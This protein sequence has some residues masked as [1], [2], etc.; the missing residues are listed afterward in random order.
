MKFATRC[1]MTINVFACAM[2]TFGAQA[3]MNTVQEKLA[4][5]SNSSRV[6]LGISAVN[7]GN[8]QRIQYGENEH[9][10]MAS[11]FKVMAVSAILKQSMTDNTL[12]Q[13]HRT[14]TPDD[15]DSNWAP[16]TEK[17]PEG[18]TIE[19]LAQ[20][21]ISYSDS[22]AINVLVRELGG[23]KMVNN[24]ARSIGDHEY[25][26]QQ[27][28]STTTPLAMEKSFRK[29]VLG[30]DLAP[31]QQKLL[32]TW[33]VNNT[34]GNLRIRAGVPKN[35]VVGDKTGTGDYGLVNDVAVLWPPKCNPIVIAIYSNQQKKDAVR[36]VA[37]LAEATRM[38]LSDF[39]KKDPCVKKALKES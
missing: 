2:I 30:H 21:A 3:T 14:Y 4:A 22:T 9:F 19:G 39:S 26:L 20:A 23:N 27:T 12:L 13:Q 36:K 32:Q 25:Q 33:L 15:I 29:L 11:T 8:A 18:M 1:L 31:K 35:W 34:T 16:V 38:I 37:V 7:T 6:K 24:F 10:K 28:D 5:L 17:H